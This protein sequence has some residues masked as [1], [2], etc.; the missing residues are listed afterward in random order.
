MSKLRKPQIGILAAC[1]LAGLAAR[2]AGPVTP[3]AAAVKV[4]GRVMVGET[5][6][7]LTLTAY[8]NGETLKGLKVQV[9]GR[10]AEE[11]ANGMYKLL[12][13]EALGAPGKP[14]QVT[15]EAPA[16]SPQPFAAI[17]ATS[18]VAPW[19]RIG[20]PANEAHF[21]AAGP[22][23]VV[24][25]SGGWAPYDLTARPETAP[26]TY[27][28]EEYGITSTRKAVPMSKFKKGSRYL[29]N[30]GFEA[31]DF[32]FSGPVERGSRLVLIARS[33][34]VRINID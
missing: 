9:A 28:L 30:V 5:V 29:L 15:I 11:L 34:P 22:D 26:G 23:L 31:R 3:P 32:T 18:L 17:T 8:R 33:M 12:V 7:M 2:A 21:S 20:E 13:Q 1:L 6:T 16:L 4:E 24:A 14:L 27:A 10:A 25:W 19:V